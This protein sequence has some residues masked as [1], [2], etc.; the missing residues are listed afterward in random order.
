MKEITDSL[1]SKGLKSTTGAKFNK[2]S[3]H[4]ILKN[5]KYIGEYKYSDIVIENGI[6][7]I[8]S[9]ELFEKVQSRM[10]TNQKAPAKAKAPKAD[11]L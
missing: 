5:R 6:P 3:L 10:T 9:N 8:V 11:G 1:N 4:S 2:S 7:A